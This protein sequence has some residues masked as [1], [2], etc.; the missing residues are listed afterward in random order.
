MDEKELSQLFPLD[1]VAPPLRIVEGGALRVGKSRITLDL[2][3]EE[4]ESGMTPE[5]MVRAYDT[6]VLADVYGA[7]A[8]YLSHRDAVRE[9][10]KR[11]EVEAAA[12]RAEIE[13]RQPRISRE[14]L[15]ARRAAKE[16]ADAAAGH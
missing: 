3:V 1:P 12:L 14:E 11:R 13:A 16:S 6:L 9:Y 4:Y 8:Y 2:I 5:D 15:L 10:M 7:I